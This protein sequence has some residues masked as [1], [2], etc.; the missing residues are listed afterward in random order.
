MF[1]GYASCDVSKGYPF[2]VMVTLRLDSHCIYV[3]YSALMEN[4]FELVNSEIAVRV[5]ILS[6]KT[7]RL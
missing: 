7:C 2:T 6:L 1:D 3:A 4:T 5:L